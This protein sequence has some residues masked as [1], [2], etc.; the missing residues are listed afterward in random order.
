MA[1][2]MTPLGTIEPVTDT[3]WTTALERN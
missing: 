3:I 2:E 1:L